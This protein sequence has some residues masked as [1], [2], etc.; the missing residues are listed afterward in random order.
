VFA[1]IGDDLN[2]DPGSVSALITSRTKAILPVH[3]T[4]KICRIDDL[5]AIV[6]SHGLAIVE[7]SA[8]AFGA[9]WR[10]RRSGSFGRLACFSMNPMKVFAACGEAGMVLTDDHELY[11][12]LVALRYNGTVNRETCVEPSLNG[13]L[14]TLQA[15]ILLRRLRDV[16]SLIQKRRDIAAEYSAQLAGLVDVPREAVG[17]RDVFYTYTIRTSKR[18]EL[19][20]FLE[21]RGVETKIQHPYLMPEQPAYRNNVRGHFPNA[22][23]LVKQ[24]LCIPVHEKLSF[25]DVHYVVD[26]IREF[27]GR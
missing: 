1:D 26:C 14:D 12:R 19:K 5:T 8:Q 9:T 3:Y 6:R 11:E 18:D 24:V 27:F 2:I 7:D 13:R 10:G 25:D 15:A 23:R 22:S 20:A 21:S 17:E 4:G 16:D